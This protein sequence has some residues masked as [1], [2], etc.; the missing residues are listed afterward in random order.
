M[1]YYVHIEDHDCNEVE[2]LTVGR[3]VWYTT[4][5]YHGPFEMFEEA[6]EFVKQQGENCFKIRIISIDI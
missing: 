6:L 1:S 2:E 3:D 5:I 4:Q